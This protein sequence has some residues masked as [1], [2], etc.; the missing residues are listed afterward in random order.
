MQEIV[1]EKL[2]QES[3]EQSFHRYEKKLCRIAYSYLRD[4][5][6]ARDAV[7]EIFTAAWRHREYIEIKTFEAYLYQSV[8]NECL[9]YRRNKELKKAVYDKI[10]MKERCVMDY[11]TRTIECCNPNELFC[12][13]IMEICRK[14]IARM[15]ELRRQILTANKF[16]GMSYKEI[17]DRNGIT[18]T[19][20]DNELRK[21]LNTLRLSL[22]DYLTILVFLFLNIK[23]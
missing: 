1:S 8:K 6:A 2:T 14:Q 19:R 23:H 10:L 21:A 17:A 16:E 18:T 15:P 12:E 22:K 3:F 11:Y 20:V 5:D 13:E 9:K 4:Q 7:N